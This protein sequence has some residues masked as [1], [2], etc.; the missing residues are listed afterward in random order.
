MNT[1]VNSDSVVHG[2]KTDHLKKISNPFFIFVIV[3]SVTILVF[4]MQESFAQTVVDWRNGVG[5]SIGATLTDVNAEN[6]LG[7]G[8]GLVIFVHD[9]NYD[10]GGGSDTGPNDQISVTITTSQETVAITLPEVGGNTGDFQ[11]RV[12]F[13]LGEHRFDVTDQI[14]VSVIDTGCSGVPF[15]IGNCDPDAIDTLD[16][17]AGFPLGGVFVTTDAQTAFGGM[18]LLLTETGPNTGVFTQTL[19]FS[20]VAQNP[21]SATLLVVPGEMIHFVDDVTGDRT[22]GLI[23]PATPGVA[24]VRAAAPETV[25]ATYNDGGGDV[26]DNLNLIDGNP[27]GRAGGGPAPPSLVNSSPPSTGGGGGENGAPPTLGLSRVNEVKLV[28]YGFFHN[29]DKYEITGFW[30][31]FDKVQINVG[32]PQSFGMKGAATYPITRVEFGLVPEV[33]MMHKAEVLVEVWTN[34][35]N[36]E[37]VVKQG[38]NLIDQSLI[39]PEV[40]VRDEDCFEGSG[41]KDCIFIG[42]KDVMFREEP[43]FEVIGLKIVD[44]KGRSSVV[45]LNDGFDIVGE[46]MNPP[47]TDLV[48]FGKKGM[49]LEKVEQVD[50]WKNIWEDEHGIQYVKNEF[51]T[52]VRQTPVEMKVNQDEYWTV[53]ERMNNNFVKLI[54]YEQARAKK[55]FDYDAIVRDT[56]ESFA[57]EEPDYK[58]R[59]NSDDFVRYMQTQTELATQLWDGK[60]IQGKLRDAVSTTT[61]KISE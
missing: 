31:P 56:P 21:A 57:Y 16:S 22:L 37:V 26:T 15:F 42:F 2:L 47:K 27:P 3:L 18:G 50:K 39:S 36:P 40:D 53:M 17:T 11:A 1:C 19:S 38:E 4:P 43:F 25:T 6:I 48:S 28:D 44:K 7:A 14:I 52:Y 20:T 49:G 23:N 54:D 61:V 12:A 29:S 59:F 30:T 55:I 9:D 60:A 45:Y 13:L 33:G 46:S 32:E 35:G 10:V 34:N 58:D 8:N 24:G 51:G 41:K 5:G